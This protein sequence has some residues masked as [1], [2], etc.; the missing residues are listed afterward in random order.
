MHDLPEILS[1]RDVATYLGLDPKSVYQ[2]VSR[3][4]LPAKRIGKRILFYRDT[5]L[6]WLGSDEKAKE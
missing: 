6:A 4:E 1:V 3:G 5:L 2:A